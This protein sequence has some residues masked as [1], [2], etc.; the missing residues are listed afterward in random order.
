MRHNA[1]PTRN[2]S[3][4]RHTAPLRDS[5]RKRLLRLSV[6][7][8]LSLCL[9]A[10][11]AA[12][13]RAL[14][15][16][17]NVAAS[18]PVPAGVNQAVPA[19]TSGES[20]AS[21][22]ANGTTPAHPHNPAPP[23]EMT[24]PPGPAPMPAPEPSANTAPFPEMRWTALSPGLELGLSS[25]PESQEKG[26]SAV[27]VVLRIDPALHHFALGMAS[28]TGQ[29]RS[30]IDWSRKHG[31][32]AGINA[33]M[34]L[35]DNVT[36]TGYMR[37]GETLNNDKMGNK[38]GAFFVAERRNGVGP[39]ADIIEREAPNWSESL[40][41]YSIVVQNYRLMDSRGKVLWPAG[42]PMHS[43]AVVAKDDQGRIAFILSQEPLTAE[44][45][46]HYLKSFPLALS[47]AMY[48]EGGAQAGLFLR[49]DNGT[50]KSVPSSF[51]GA[52]AF[53]APEGVVH[54]W[55]GRQ[56]LLNTRGNPEA[57]VPNVLSVTGAAKTPP[58][59]LP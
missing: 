17:K 6:L 53:A 22:Q 19:K 56:S 20:S 23:S 34:Y 39:A 12:G 54:V 52:S 47:T 58:A 9:S 45:F 46:A 21:A 11:P 1:L 8:V 10:F 2:A 3:F 30:L 37:N 42:G 18:A 43:I 24:P 33:S 55:K 27:F 50:A 38:L 14:A 5:S 29:A 15:A 4:V 31:L 32:R 49:V 7:L 35:P 28:E 48:V 16:E 51:A 57:P 44:R 25:L 41:E 36:S 40:E 13:L 26:T 59:P